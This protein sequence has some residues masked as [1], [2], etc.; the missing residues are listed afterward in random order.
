VSEDRKIVRLVPGRVR[1]SPELADRAVEL[2]RRGLPMR[3][4]ATEMNLGYRTLMDWQR[5]HPELRE[6]LRTARQ[7]AISEGLR[8]GKGPGLTS[9][10]PAKID[11]ILGHLRQGCGRGHAAAL[12]GLHPTTLDRWLDGDQELERQVMEAEGHLQ[13]RMLAIVDRASGSSWQAAAWTLERRFPELYAR[14]FEMTAQ[15]R[16]RMA[17]GIGSGL[18]DLVVRS[19]ADADLTAEQQE[20]VRKRLTDALTKAAG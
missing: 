3:Q 6:R 8:I 20:Q 2:T 19:L 16:A 14:R 1:Y 12:A 13:A 15:E 7:A 10:T 17:K 9:R 11:R 4:V 5:D 18:A